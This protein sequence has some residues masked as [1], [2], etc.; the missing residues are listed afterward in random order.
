MKNIKINYSE[1][2]AGEFLIKYFP[3]LIILCM[4]FLSASPKYNFK[5]NDGNFNLNSSVQ[6]VTVSDTNNSGSYIQKLDSSIE[7]NGGSYKVKLKISALKNI[8]IKNVS[9]VNGN[10]MIS[11]KFPGKPQGRI[12]LHPFEEA[13]IELEIIPGN[14]SNVVPFDVIYSKAGKE[15]ELK[16]RYIIPVTP[17][18]SCS[19]PNPPVSPAIVLKYT[20]NNVQHSVNVQCAN[21][22]VNAANIPTGTSLNLEVNVNCTQTACNKFAQVYL[23]DAN[24]NNYNTLVMNGNSTIP[25]AIPGNVILPGV[26]TI[27]IKYW[28]GNQNNNCGT[29]T[30]KVTASCVCNPVW[31]SINGYELP[32]NDLIG[33]IQCGSAFTNIETGRQYVFKTSSPCL[34]G[35]CQTSY[36]WEIK[37]MQ[38]GTSVFGGP[39]LLPG[40]NLVEIPFSPIAAGDYVIKIKKACP[41]TGPCQDVCTFKV[42][43]INRCDCPAEGSGTIQYT[44]GTYRKDFPIACNSTL[45][46]TNPLPKNGVINVNYDIRCQEPCTKSF[47]WEVKDPSGN[48]LTTVAPSGY[49]GGNLPA[50]FH[51]TTSLTGVYTIIIKSFCGLQECPPC[52]FR[53]SIEDLPCKLLNLAAQ[54]NE[55]CN[56]QGVPLTLENFSGAGTD[57]RWY[58]STTNT[59]PALDAGNLIKDPSNNPATGVSYNTGNLINS[60]N[61]CGVVTYYFQCKT[62]NPECYS[63]IQIIKVYPSIIDIFINSTNGFEFCTN[64][65]TKLTASTSSSTS[66]N[67]GCD[68]RWYYQN[69]N[70]WN[71]PQLNLLA[72]FL[73][74][75]CPDKFIEYKFKVVFCEG[76]CNQKS[77]EVKIKV[78]SFPKLKSIKADSDRI[79]Y[80]EATTLRIEEPCGSEFQW[81]IFDSTANS[82]IDINGATDIKLNTNRLEETKYYRVKIKNGP[83]GEVISAI[84]SVIVQKQTSVTIY[85]TGNCGNFICPN[86]TLSANVQGLFD[87]TTYFDWYKDGAEIPGSRNVPSMVFTQPGVYSVKITDP[88]CGNVFSNTI[89]V[90]ELEF[91]LFQSKCPC[92]P[93]PAEFNVIPPN[94]SNLFYE[95][96]IN[97]HPFPAPSSPN[98]NPPL[99]NAGDVVSVKVSVPNGCS[100][101]HEIIV[102]GCTGCQ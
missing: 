72:S 27:K 73:R 49:G 11:I 38:S 69:R 61:P 16:L 14:A 60:T 75:K 32:D 55:V 45:N 2:I 35:N 7:T 43:V 76:K 36:S 42:L 84:K 23:T 80:L 100:K 22:A 74:A 63:N 15:N 18:V 29:C 30:F 37:N 41:G 65:S 95:W 77:K 19:C 81:Q 10:D 33:S 20:E 78:F 48:T 90:Q 1:I 9:A 79:C 46:P 44:N 91:G 92:L 87:I 34:P 58:M 70:I 83:C 56:N 4:C 99:V 88:I 64:T 57:V 71:G 67:C 89:P 13:V 17:S 25:L 24:G 82:F 40:S 54:T 101:T 12:D 3:I 26:S 94:C 5:F 59:N 62:S 28:C 51:F 102:K 85:S 50:K 53:V 96:S 6:A 31:S 52:V 97:G 47:S 93:G 66:E 98:F 86:I 39:V 68:I 8:T 21:S